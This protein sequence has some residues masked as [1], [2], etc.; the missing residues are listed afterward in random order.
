[1]GRLEAKKRL[2]FY[3]AQPEIVEAVRRR[4]S[5]PHTLLGEPERCNVLDPCA[6]KGDALE[7]LTR[8]LKGVHRYAVE[9]D[10]AR[11]AEAKER[12][13][14]KA[15]VINFGYEDVRIPDE[16]MSVLWLN[17]P[18]EWELGGGMREEYKFLDNLTGTLVP[19]GVL[20]F[21]IP[22]SAVSSV[23]YK[24]TSS[25]KGVRVFKGDPN[26]KQFVILARHGQP[27]WEETD[28]NRRALR[29]RDLAPSIL[30][31]PE[32]VE[33][34]FKI[35]VPAGPERVRMFPTRLNPVMVEDAF[36][37]SDVFRVLESAG[38]AAPPGINRD[39]ELVVPLTEELL[40]MLLQLGMVNGQLFPKGHPDCCIIHGACRKIT[41]SRSTVDEEDTI[42]ERTR[43]I[44]DTT[45]TVAEFGTGDV[46]VLSMAL[47]AP[48]E[49]PAGDEFGGSE[50]GDDD[51]A[52]EPELNEAVAA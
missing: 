18:Y 46:Y 38:V 12:L 1:M 27:T 52:D 42:I 41:R 29:D 39:I 34:R 20:V 47:D 32:V 4:L 16:S 22:D 43:E 13:S 17:P 7:I 9:L 11:A 51:G 37:D 49:R 15:V 40:A 45:V 8:G 35:S 21:L 2:G 25:Y 14:R 26:W 48:G 3:P 23:F 19:G 28:A 6:G 33:D 50:A 36:L 5:F 30:D 10:A 31:T 24:L 44:P